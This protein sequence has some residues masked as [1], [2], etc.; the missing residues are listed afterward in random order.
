MMSG[1]MMSRV[2]M[3]RVEAG[4]NAHKPMDE[5]GVVTQD[6][7]LNPGAKVC[8]DITIPQGV[9]SVDLMTRE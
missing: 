1:L 6:L 8:N 4:F 9:R 3:S 2:M 7:I 5:R